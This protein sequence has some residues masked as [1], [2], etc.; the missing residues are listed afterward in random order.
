LTLALATFAKNLSFE[1]FASIFSSSNSIPA[2]LEK[3]S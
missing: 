3:A 2:S 1:I